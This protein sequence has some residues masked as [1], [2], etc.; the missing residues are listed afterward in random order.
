MDAFW[1][2]LWENIN[3][4]LLAAN[5]CPSAILILGKRMKKGDREALFWKSELCPLL[6]LGAYCACVIRLA[7]LVTRGIQGDDRSV[8]MAL[9]RVL[10]AEG[11]IAVY[12]LLDRSGRNRSRGK[13]ESVTVEYGICLLLTASAAYQ[14]HGELSLGA[15][16]GWQI[17]YLLLFFFLKTVREQRER[18][19]LEARSREEQGRQRQRETDYMRNVDLQYQ[20]TRELWHDLKNHIAV[21]QILAGEEKYGE[22]T[23]YL[24]SFQRDVDSRMIPS[25]TGCAPVDALLGD[26]LY[27]ARQAGIR[28]SL[29]IC[30]L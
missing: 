30:D 5:L 3:P 7:E 24:V 26:K 10:M 28:M 17:G 23:D 6:E 14:G 20:R 22:L 21:L 15:E 9:I 11:L 18:K 27:R 4:G 2:A 8:I 12:L 1:T 29:Q 16:F 19:T 25:R 13:A